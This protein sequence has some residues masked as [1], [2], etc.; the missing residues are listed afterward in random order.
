[1]AAPRK[2]PQDH[3]KPEAE[4]KAEAQLRFEEVDGSEHLKPLADVKASDQIRFS[5]RLQEIISTTGVEVDEPYWHARTG[6]RDA[7]KDAFMQGRGITV[8]RLDATPFYGTLTESM[9]DA[10]RSALS[11]AE[12]AV[13]GTNTASLHPLQLALPLHENGVV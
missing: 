8:L 12:N 4:A 11:V 13:A 7:R 1:M 6:D 5:G 10:V 2:A 9:V 3:K